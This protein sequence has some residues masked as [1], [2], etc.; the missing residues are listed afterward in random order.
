MSLQQLAVVWNLI[1]F[2]LPNLEIPG[3]GLSPEPTVFVTH[4]GIT[5]HSD[6]PLIYPCAK[7][8]RPCG[9]TDLPP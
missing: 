3:Q 4:M 2:P 1:K 7:V 8:P 6:L 5:T 9:I